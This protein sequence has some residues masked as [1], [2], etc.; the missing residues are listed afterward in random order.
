MK[1]RPYTPI[2]DPDLG[3][4]FRDPELGTQNWGPRIGDPELGTQNWGPRI[5][6]PEL[7]TPNWEAHSYLGTPILWTPI[8]GKNISPKYTNT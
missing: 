8:W 5:G 7:G 2:W 3:P 1:W 6:D 4:Q